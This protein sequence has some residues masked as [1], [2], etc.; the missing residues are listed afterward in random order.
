MPDTQ[1]ERPVAACSKRIQIVV[2]RDADVRTDSLIRLITGAWRDAGHVVETVRYRDIDANA[3]VVLPH[4]D[5]TFIPDAF[6]ERAPPTAT[7]NYQLRDIS[8]AT[9]CGHVVRRDDRWG[10]P[11]I[12]KTN[13]N[14]FGVPDAVRGLTRG[15][16]A[17]RLRRLLPWRMG[18]VLPRGDYPVLP[19]LAAVPA[20]V[21]TN[22]EFV[23]E[24]FLP[25]RRGEFFVT[26][27]WIFLGSR[28][29]NQ[30]V[31][32]RLPVIKAASAAQV[33]R[34]EPPPAAI[35]AVR[36]RLGM[37]YGKIDW[38]L[39]AEGPVVYDV[40]PTPTAA[41]RSQRHLAIARDLAAGLA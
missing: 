39:S 17:A 3:D 33:E 19:G 14:C 21:W 35:Q 41:A 30:A 18:R 16:G 15:L 11:V 6:L 1:H 29:Y 10:G 40:N 20:W 4:F 24:R 5:R 32:S 2:E 26:R 34:C 9:V 38:A 25:E 31:L 27:N 8:K 23:V 37:D 12:V 7:L 36:A 28:D 13:R 22:P